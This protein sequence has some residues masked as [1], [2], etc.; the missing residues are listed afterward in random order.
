MKSKRKLKNNRRKLTMSVKIKKEL[1]NLT[2]VW[3]K[4]GSSKKKSKKSVNR[5]INTLKKKCR[6]QPGNIG[7]NQPGN[8]GNNQ[9]GNIGNNQPDN[10]GNNQP[11]NNIGNNQPG[12]NQQDDNAAPI[13]KRPKKTRK[14]PKKTQ[15]RPN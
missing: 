10:I 7:N 14:R 3:L 9:P 5:F 4:S 15:K 12:N 2:K 13:Q 6:N 8:I 1:E 11:G